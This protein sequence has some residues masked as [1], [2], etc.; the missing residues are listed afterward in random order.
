P[1]RPARFGVASIL[2]G[3]RV[4]A[5]ILAIAAALASAGLRGAAFTVG[6]LRRDGIVVPFATFDGRNWSSR[7]PAPALE[8]TVPINLQSVPSGWWGP[9]GPLA[10]WEAWVAGTNERQTIHAGQPDWIDAHWFR[11]IGLRTD[12]R[13]GEFPPPPQEQPYP[14]DGLAVSPPQPIERIQTVPAA[15]A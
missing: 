1:A 15:A 4:V 12:Y 9:T 13:A 3:M 7:W 14:K 11:Q 6:V 2:R 8:L 10:S 5:G